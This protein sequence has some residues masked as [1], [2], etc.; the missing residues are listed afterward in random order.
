MT[1]PPSGF[2]TFLFTDIEGSTKRWECQASAMATAIADHDRILKAVISSLGG[3][4]LKTIGDAFCATFES[5]VDALAAAHAAQ[6]A[7]AAED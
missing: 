1:T 3:F 6:V 7:V 5:P 2:V 4:V